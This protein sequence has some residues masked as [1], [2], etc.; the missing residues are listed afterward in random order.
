MHTLTSMSVLL[1]VGPKCTL[2]ASHAAPHTVAM[3]TGQ[4]DRRTDARP[5][6]RY[7]PWT[8]PG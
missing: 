5:S 4:T 8:R 6:S 1:I 7:S 3:L 2:A